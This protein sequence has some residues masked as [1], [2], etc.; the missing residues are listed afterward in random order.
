MDMNLGKLQKME[1][2]KKDWC[3]AVRGVAKSWTWLGNWTTGCKNIPIFHRDCAKVLRLSRSNSEKNLEL[4]LAK[5]L[6]RCPSLHCPMDRKWPLPQAKISLKCSFWN[7]PSLNVPEP[8]FA[9]RLVT[10]SISWV[11]SNH[12]TSEVFST[13]KTGQKSSLPLLLPQVPPS[14]WITQVECYTYLDSSTLMDSNTSANQTSQK[15]SWV[16]D[17]LIFFYRFYE[18][19]THY[20]LCNYLG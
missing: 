20:P 8:C 16:S 2:D 7:N 15:F 12:K 18:T 17:V 11:A 19:D 14:Y 6:R 1:R 3:A 9:T 4:L 13:Q 5:S 10:D